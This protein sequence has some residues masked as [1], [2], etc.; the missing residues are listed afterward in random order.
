VGVVGGG[1]GGGDRGRSSLLQTVKGADPLILRETSG[2][3]TAPCILMRRLSSRLLLK[4]NSVPA[5]ESAGKTEDI[6]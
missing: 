1:G 3:V 2:A 5:A 6:N 4:G